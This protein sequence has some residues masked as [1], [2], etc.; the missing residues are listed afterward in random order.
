MFQFNAISLGIIFIALGLVFWL[1]IRFLMQVVPRTKPTA[2]HA[3]PL[4]NTS[5]QPPIRLDA[6]LESD[7]LTVNRTLLGLLLTRDSRIKG[8]ANRRDPLLRL[9]I[10]DHHAPFAKME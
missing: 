9:I 10:H 3:A 8:R 5:L 2:P 1:A 4:E 6:V 7:D